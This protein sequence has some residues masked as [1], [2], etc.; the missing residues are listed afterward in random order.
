MH[1]PPAVSVLCIPHKRVDYT[2]NHKQ[3]QTATNAA[4]EGMRLGTHM[5]RA[6][7]AYSIHLLFASEHLLVLLWKVY[8][9][10]S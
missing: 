9:A 4:E 7:S 10:I 8:G 6:L 3:C 5:R 1:N 2:V